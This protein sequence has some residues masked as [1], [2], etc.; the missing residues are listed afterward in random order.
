MEVERKQCGA[1]ERAPDAAV[2]HLLAACHDAAH[3]QFDNEISAALSL[4]LPPTI[5]P[6]E[7]V[8][9]PARGTIRSERSRSHQTQYRG[10]I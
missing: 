7:D 4:S 1:G 6:V 10:A 2:N 8:S 9:E 5:S 3:C